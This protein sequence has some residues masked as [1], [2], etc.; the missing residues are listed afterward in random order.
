MGIYVRSKANPKEWLHNVQDDNV[1]L[2]VWGSR[3]RAHDY[4]SLGWEVAEERAKQFNGEV[5]FGEE[6]SWEG[7]EPPEGSRLW[8]CERELA[9]T[10]KEVARLKK[11]WS[12]MR[13][14]VPRVLRRTDGEMTLLYMDDLEKE[15]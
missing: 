4:T 3:E 10:R 6:A 15:E 14:W 2:P 9:K 7:G 12:A 5:L 1:E 11:R 8:R 13:T